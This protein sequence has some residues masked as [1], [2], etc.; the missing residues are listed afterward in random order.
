MLIPAVQRD[1][2]SA[3]FFDGTAKGLLLARRCGNGHYMPYPQGNGRSSARCHTCLSENVDWVPVSG[4]AIL[5]SWIVV[6]SRDG[7]SRSVAGIVELAEGPWM[8]ALIDGTT[9]TELR[10]GLPLAAGFV[11]SDGGESIPIFTPI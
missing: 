2:E 9:G 5:V 6:H 4:R 8:N 10:A 3:E 1:D 11:P 7:S